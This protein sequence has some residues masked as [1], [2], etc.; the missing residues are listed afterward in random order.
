ML[1]LTMRTNGQITSEGP[2]S[3]FLFPGFGNAIVKMRNAELHSMLMNFNTVSE[4]MV[5]KKNDRLYDLVNEEMVDTIYLQDSKFV[6]TGGVFYEV[7]WN[8]QIPFYVSYKGVLL[9]PGTKAGY[10]VNSQVS[11]T[12]LRT[13]FDT[14]SGNYNLELPSDYK[15]QI[16]LTYLF[17]KDDLLLSFTNERQLLKIAPEKAS[18]LKQFIKNNKIKF[19]ELADMRNLA[20]YYNLLNSKQN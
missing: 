5:Y 4:K 12:K 14:S 6:P 20:K 9:P 8:D 18:E 11:N 17:R 7:L 15:V 3:Q 10:G 16:N 2:L 13:S 1:L 19:T